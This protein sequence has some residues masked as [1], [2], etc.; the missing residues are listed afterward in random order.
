[1]YFGAINSL[2]QTLLKL[3]CPG[4]PDVYQGQEMWDFSLVDPDNRRPVDFELRA[5]TAADALRAAEGSD[6]RDV[7]HEMLRQ[8]SRR[9]D[10]V[11]GDDAGVEL[12]AASTGSCFSREVTAVA[13]SHGKEE[14]V[15]AF[16]RQHDGQ[17]AIVAAP[18]LSYTLMKGK[19]E[20]PIGQCMGRFGVGAAA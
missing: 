3:T 14:H 6:L 13:R 10:Q 11:V 17:V 18:R 20:P 12:S 4:V 8:L 5:R 7:C 15:V 2:A 1:M 9:P 16:A 19:E